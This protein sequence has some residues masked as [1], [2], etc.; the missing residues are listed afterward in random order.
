MDKMQRSS[1]SIFVICLL[2]AVTKMASAQDGS[3][4]LSFDTDGI[5]VTSLDSS[6]LANSIAI[7]SDGKI[8][9]AGYRDNGIGSVNDFDFALVRYN[10]NGTLDLTFGTD[11]IVI[12]PIGSGSEKAEEVLIQSDGKILVA[13]S[14]H[15]G[16]NDDFALVRYNSNGTLDLTFSGDGIVTTSITAYSDRAASLALQSDGKI[17]VCGRS[18]GSSYWSFAIVRY[19]TDGS[20]DLTFDTDGIAT[21]SVGVYD[22]WASSLAV[23]ADGKILVAG[24]SYGPPGR[25]AVVRYNSDGT[26]D[27]TFDTDG[28]VITLIGG[29]AEAE[30]IALQ[31]DGKIVVAGTNLDGGYDADFALLRYNTNG[32]LDL[33]FNTDGIITADIGGYGDYC[34]SVSIQD[35]GRIVV[36]GMDSTTFAVMRYL[37]NGNLDNTFGSGGLVLTSFE[38]GNWATSSAIQSDSKIILAGYS[39]NGDH[40]DFALARYNATLNAEITETNS[41]DISFY[42]NPSDDIIYIN[43]GNETVSITILDQSGRKVFDYPNFAGSGQIDLSSLSSGQY[44]VHVTSESGIL[45]K[46]LVV[47]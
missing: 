46:P 33:T 34:N 22:S 24:T 30:S 9:V 13:G 18:G 26:L 23:Q 4:D 38:Q 35:D 11:G 41:F 6:S 29:D 1:K 31:D 40:Y 3:L 8:V 37:E 28:M 14:S 43:A 21:T 19:N 39:Y 47:K 17:L 5:V 7:Q 12:T 15:N 32:S 45:T 44:L 27:A 10:T 2:S 20:L 36:A 25:F 42:P 16:T